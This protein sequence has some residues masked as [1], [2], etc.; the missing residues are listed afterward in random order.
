MKKI[1][2]KPKALKKEETIPEWFNKAQEKEKM[3]EEEKAE[4]EEFFKE[5]V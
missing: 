4:L 3:N 5:F 2:E 1:K